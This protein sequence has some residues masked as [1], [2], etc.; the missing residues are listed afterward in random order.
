MNSDAYALAVII[1]IAALVSAWV[2][3]FAVSWVA[4]IMWEETR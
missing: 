2:L 4:F 3:V 1:A